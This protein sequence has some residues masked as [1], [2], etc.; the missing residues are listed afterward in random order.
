[1]TRT[2]EAGNA[3]PMNVS[4]H[5]QGTGKE[6]LA[7]QPQ[8]PAPIIDADEVQARHAARMIREL[9]HQSRIIEVA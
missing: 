8:K 1:M 3:R 7:V 5:I 6:V 2:I 9:K 4:N